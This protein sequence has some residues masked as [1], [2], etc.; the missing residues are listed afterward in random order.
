MGIFSIKSWHNVP[1]T[2][3]PVNGPAL[4]DMERRI[5]EA[6]ENGTIVP[7]KSFIIPASFALQGAVSLSS[8][9]AVPIFYA[10]EK[11]GTE[12]KLIA[13]RYKIESGTAVKFRLQ[14]NGANVTGFGTEG[15]PL[16][17]T[18]TAATTEPT[19]VA[20]SNSDSLGILISAVEGSPVGLTVTLYIEIIC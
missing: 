8:S 2:E 14:R 15:S 6:V 18:G 17:A 11:A 9:L 10:P 12:A 7:K 3:T 5:T 16:S 4:E 20:L 1:S 19:A 13:C